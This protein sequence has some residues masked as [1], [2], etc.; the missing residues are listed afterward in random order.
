MRVALLPVV[1]SVC[2]CS[3]SAWAQSWH[4]AVSDVAALQ[5]AAA[6][7]D[8]A[9]IAELAWYQFYSLGGLRYDDG[10]VL[11][12][13]RRAA[14]KG[15]PLGR[16]GYAYALFRSTRWTKEREPGWPYI[17]QALAASPEHPVVQ[18]VAGVYMRD[19]S[20]KAFDAARA[21]QLCQ[22]SWEAGEPLGGFEL[23]NS[24]SGRW[25]GLEA[26]VAKAEELAVALVER[27]EFAAAA[28]WLLAGLQSGRRG[29]SRD[30]ELKALE[31]VRAAA[32]RGDPAAQFRMAWVH[33][34]DGDME[35]A[36]RF[37]E[38]AARNGHFQANGNLA[39]DF[40]VPNRGPRYGRIKEKAM[41]MIGVRGFDGGASDRWPMHFGALYYRDGYWDGE[42]DFWKANFALKQLVEGG[43][44]SERPELA[45]LY[46]DDIE[47][48]PASL[49]R[50][51]I[52]MAL[53]RSHAHH[54]IRTPERLAMAYAGEYADDVP[55]DLA[56]A[57]AAAVFA[58][59]KGSKVWTDNKLAE[60]EGRMGAEQRAEAKRLAADEFPQALR[61]RRG[62]LDLLV[63]EGYLSE[64]DAED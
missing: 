18:A 19:S 36:M 30:L 60:L 58:R 24:F 50:T 9:A 42:P 63:A 39:E 14:S 35:T 54:D 33:R 15:D 21:R 4:G 16:A 48:L 28:E 52:G 61:H 46:L 57:H 49:H 53:L 45:Q 2:C 26:D 6:E 43:H 27:F 62:A 8:G 34:K 1:G 37:Y 55:V 5:A 11:D 22:Q 56:R 25:D 31:V 32:L 23:M 17:K 51:E 44:C 13:F 12:A 47:G 40:A 10:E 20:L 7:G 29:L 64:D 3:A 38:L 59:A 41:W